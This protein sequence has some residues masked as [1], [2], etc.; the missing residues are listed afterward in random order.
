MKTKLASS[1]V[2]LSLS[3][4]GLAISIA[5]WAGP[6]GEK[7]SV[8]GEVIDV[9]CYFEDGSHG[10]EHKQCG[11]ACAKAGNPIGLLD[12]RGNVYVLMGME[13]HQSAKDVLIPKISEKVTVDGILV[14]KGGTQ[15]I[16]VSSI[17]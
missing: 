13:D 15:A 3:V 7:V 8:A 11:T 1:A 2:A 6:Q 10:A 5:A 17:N 16:Y 9:W 12:E 14:K 4:F